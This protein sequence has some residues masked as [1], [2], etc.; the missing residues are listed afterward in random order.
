MQSKRKRIINTL[1]A[2]IVIAFILFTIGVIIDPLPKIDREFSAEVQEHANPT[3]DH[4]MHYISWAG[5]MP[6][7]V[8]VVA[9][10]ILIFLV[11]GYKREALFTLL[12]A[13]S[14]LV[15]TLVKLVVNRPRPGAPLVHVLEKTEQQSFPSGH[16]LFY[17][18]FFGFIILVMYNRKAI[19]KPARLII[20]G[21]CL[22][23][24]LLI[25][26]S[27]I[28]L[29]AH[30]FSDVTAGALLGFICLYVLG[31]FYLKT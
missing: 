30:W 25:P 11:V 23:L 18:V 27:R 5:Y 31:Y 13:L 4:V 7:S 2:I 14:G 21:I 8:Y 22:L 29:G 10:A 9:G 24:I 1:M 19:H 15:S 16:V 3:L 17:T 6:N 28:Y 20:S 26:L 12:S